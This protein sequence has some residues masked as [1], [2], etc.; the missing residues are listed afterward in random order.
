[1]AKFP[2]PPAPTPQE[3]FQADYDRA[4]KYPSITDLVELLGGG[5]RGRERLTEA[6]CRGWLTAE[7]AKL[8]EGD[9]SRLTCWLL[10]Y[11]VRLSLREG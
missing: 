5:A 7:D 10:A 4:P 3:V 6:Y 1:M 8:L 9:D 2:T 11:L